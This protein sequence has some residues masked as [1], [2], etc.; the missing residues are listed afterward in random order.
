[1]LKRL[2]TSDILAGGFLSA[3]ARMTV[4]V[5]DP[6]V[7][8]VVVNW[9]G[10]KH[11]ETCLGSLDRQSYTCRR[12][13]LVDNGS[14]D[15]SVAFVRDRF[16]EVEII[17]NERN[18]GFCRANNQGL[19]RAVAAGAPYAVLLNN[20]TETDP[21]WLEALVR[22]AD[23]LP[24]AGALASKM[25]M[26][27]RRDI[28]NSTGLCCSA[29]GCAWDRGFG[30][31]DGP[32]W[33]EPATVIGASGGAF[34]VRTAALDRVGCGTPGIL[35]STYRQPWST[36]NFPLQWRLLQTGTGARISAAGTGCV[37]LCVSSPSAM[38]C[39]CTPGCC[40][41]KQKLS[42]GR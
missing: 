8:V 4:T 30:Q 33:N 14:T 34:F 36:T 9:N 20:D 29:I 32:V 27:D 18:L 2:H 42:A 23:R 16:P 25:L 40:V 19:R 35:S 1:M 6:V 41:P 26:F 13:L 10:R 24:Q 7:F 28:V 17:A 38:C 3:D 11:L 5:N 12:V 22:A 21:G 15:G 37:W 39:A 31:P